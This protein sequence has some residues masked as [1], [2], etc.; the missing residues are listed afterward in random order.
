MKAW[1]K[2]NRAA[3]ADSWEQLLVALLVIGLM[4]TCLYPKKC[5]GQAPHET[6]L[7]VDSG[8]MAQLGRIADTATIEHIRC[9][10]GVDR[11]DTILVDVAWEPKVTYANYT[12]VTFEHCPLATVG[13]W[14][15]HI[16]MRFPILNGDTARYVRVPPHQMCYLSRPD[17]TAALAM[18]HERLSIVQVVDSVACAWIREGKTLQR[19]RQ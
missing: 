15:N 12:M 16:A 14:H 18:K 13:T 7:T 11:G 8:M 17:S 4:V 10:L 1:I 2:R 9:L 3:V 19:V 5:R 6:H